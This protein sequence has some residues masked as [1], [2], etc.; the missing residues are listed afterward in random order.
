VFDAQKDQLILIDVRAFW[1]RALLLLPVVVVVVVV[2]FSVRW[3]L[4][5]TLAEFAPPVDQG[6]IE[7]AQSAVSFAPSDPLAHFVLG[8]MEKDAFAPERLSVA[9][10][11]YEEAVR[12]SPYDYRYWL[13]LGRARE[14]AGDVAGGE[15]ALRRA[16]ELGP[17]YSYPR[18][19]L[20][21]LLF[22]SNRRDEAFAELRKA[23]ETNAQML[24]QICVLAWYGYD[25]N[26]AEMETALGQR[27]QTRAALAVFLASKGKADD[28]LRLWKGLSKEEKANLQTGT[29]NNLFRTLFQA[30]QYRAALEIAKEIKSDSAGEVGKLINGSFESGISGNDPISFGWRVSQA[31]K[32]QITIDPQ[33]KLDGGRSLRITYN[34]YDAN[35]FANVWQT[36]AVEPN[37]RYRLEFSIRTKDLKS[38]GAPIIE[39]VY[40]LDSRLIAQSKPFPIETNDWQKMTIEFDSPTTP[41]GVIIRTN[42]I[43]CEPACL[44]FGTVWYDN[45]NLQRIGRT[46]TGDKNSGK[47]NN[48]KQKPTPAR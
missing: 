39:L 3:Y 21:N 13:A 45:F 15:Q 37:T 32:A 31:D 43:P 20:G 42:R 24:P 33:V 2:T 41:D 14:L 11:H 28:A 40:P 7:S 8:N 35:T 27:P 25:N 36:V 12:L 44:I 5:N 6:G 47:G 4:G 22:R 34:G 19:Y 38:I 23:G 30:E 10:K 9:I 18:W 1:R 29:D 16:V 46:E 26:I 17:S 48:A